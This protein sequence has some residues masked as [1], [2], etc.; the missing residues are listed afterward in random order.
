MTPDNP[1]WAMARRLAEW[2]DQQGFYDYRK[3]MQPF[4]S[5]TMHREDGILPS[6]DR[7]TVWIAVDTTHVGE[8]YIGEVRFW[9]I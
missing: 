7:F 2:L 4:L 8:S 9:T 6:G 1:L 5:N 3:D